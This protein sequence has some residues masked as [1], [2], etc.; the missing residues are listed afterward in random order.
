MSRQKLR[1][2]VAGA[3]FVCAGASSPA[4]AGLPINDPLLV[5]KIILEN[6][7]YLKEFADKMGINDDLIDQIAEMTNLRGEAR[8]NATANIIRR[9]GMSMADVQN[10]KQLQKMAPA[11]HACNKISKS[12]EAACAEVDR[13]NFL[14]KV[15]QKRFKNSGIKKEADGSISYTKADR[16]KAISVVAHAV[17]KE[18]DKLEKA[19]VDGGD[20]STLPISP[21]SVMNFKGLETL[22][23][24]EVAA[25][26]MFIDIVSPI[27]YERLPGKVRQTNEMILKRQGM[28]ARQAVASGMFS[29]I[30]SMR[31]PGEDNL[32]TLESL[33]AAEDGFI[34]GIAESLSDQAT[35]A[36]PST[37][38][39]RRALL[40]QLSAQLAVEFYGFKSDLN[41]EVA[42]ATW[43]SHRLN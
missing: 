36:L 31:L 1:A 38:E 32:S 43:L 5:G 25:G 6:S 22:T 9:M 10:I 20:L 16:A 23:K 13:G 24:E 8:D 35:G 34:S 15:I 42:L 4:W 28:L 39:G 41:R 14:S 2:A 26:E 18:I 37:E 12:K 3:F 7:A 40:Y 21:F 17:R 19:R 11:A 27:N 30:L 33:S 29:S